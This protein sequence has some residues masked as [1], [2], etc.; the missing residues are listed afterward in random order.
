M[1]LVKA[2]TLCLRTLQLEQVQRL[3]QSS[4]RAGGGFLCPNVSNAGTY[5]LKDPSINM[6]EPRHAAHAMLNVL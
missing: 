2:G 4:A 1:S 6:R 3:A 5:R